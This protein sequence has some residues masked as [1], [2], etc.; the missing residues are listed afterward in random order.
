MFLLFLLAT[1][2]GHCLQKLYFSECSELGDRKAI[3]TSDGDCDSSPLTIFENLEC[4]FSCGPGYYLNFLN[5]QQVCSEC[6]VGTYSLGGTQ[7][8]GVGGIPWNESLPKLI[9]HCWTAKFTDQLDYNCEKWQIIENSLVSGKSFINSTF[10]SSLKFEINLVNPGKLLIIYR[11]ELESESDLLEFSVKINKVKKLNDKSAAGKIWNHFEEE[12]VD[13]TYQV[14]VDFMKTPGDK[15]Q[16]K[17]IIHSIAV[18]GAFYDSECLKCHSS[19]PFSSGNSCMVCDYNQYFDQGGCKDCPEGTYSH[20]GSSNSSECLQRFECSMKDFVQLFTVCEKSMMKMYYEWKTPIFCNNSNYQLPPS[21]DNLPCEPCPSG[22]IESQNNEITECRPCPDGEFLDT[23]NSAK[24]CQKCPSGTISLKSIS[25]TNWTAIPDLFT[26]YCKEASGNFC[27]LLDGWIPMSDYLSTGQ[28]TLKGVHLYLQTSVSIKSFE[29]ILNFT[30]KIINKGS[31]SFELYIDKRLY[32]ILNSEEKKD[33]L[34]TLPNGEHLIELAYVK[35]DA[36]AEEVRIYQL[37]IIG[38]GIGGASQ[39]IQCPV[40]YASQQGS[41]ICSACPIGHTSDSGNNNC[42]ECVEGT[43]NLY[44]GNK[45]SSCPIGSTN[46]LDHSLCV[47]LPYLNF[48]DS[49]YFLYALSNMSL[50]SSQE[51]VCSSLSSQLYCY[52]TFYGPIDSDEGEFYLSIINP[53]LLELPGIPYLETQSIGYNFGVIKQQTVLGTDNKDKCKQE[54]KIINFGRK[55]KEVTDYGNHFSIEY[56]DG[57]LCENGERFRTEVGVYCDKTDGY[58]W[59]AIYSLDN[60]TVRII[61][62]SKYG[63]RI[64]KENDMKTVTGECLNGQQDVSVIEGEDCISVVKY[65]KTTQ[66]CMDG[67]YKNELFIVYFIIGFCGIL[68]ILYIIYFIK[69]KKIE[70]PLIELEK[71]KPPSNT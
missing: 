49:S 28:I 5:G 2:Y 44:K 71:P 52:E 6:P 23:S 62:E 8:F 29:G 13:G 41:A 35:L 27:K 34:I 32:K 58:G 16:S 15:P 30:Y 69:L 48:T 33:E 59:P 7:V 22:Y 24:S 26:T 56:S 70:V 36:D 37:S 53:S 14:E 50:N 57:D 12:L 18:E 47:A 17:V 25:Y 60:C 31:G 11:K 39:C 66:A 21:I 40:G 61:W 45:C 51:N 42:E 20:R 9:N 3:L 19:V 46:N 54:E 55:L 10:V 43:V 63:C 65:E 64:C 67:E 1:V 38:S 4:E 68:T